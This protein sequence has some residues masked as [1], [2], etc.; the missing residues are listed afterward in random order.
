MANNND[1]E[2]LQQALWQQ[3]VA[4]AEV[5][6]A[7]NEE[8]ENEEEE[9]DEEDEEEEEAAKGRRDRQAIS[10]SSFVLAVCTG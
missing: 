8:A 6:E 4:E 5:E 2:N 1:D 3:L 7:E 9:E 10:W